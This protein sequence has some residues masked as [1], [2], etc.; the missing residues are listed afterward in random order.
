[1]KIF[2]SDR[3]SG[4]MRQ[5]SDLFGMDFKT[6]LSPGLTLSET[7]NPNESE[8]ILQF[9]SNIL[10]TRSK[11]LIRIELNGTTRNKMK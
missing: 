8:S 1:M 6:K 4:M 9:I 11:K 5:I 10:N 3:N 2:V 7:F